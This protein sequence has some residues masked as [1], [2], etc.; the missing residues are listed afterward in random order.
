MDEASACVVG[1]WVDGWV[2]YVCVVL[3]LGGGICTMLCGEYNVGLLEGL[4]NYF[5]ECFI[6]I[7]EFFLGND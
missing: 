6:Y 1:S 3:V 2:G 4:L 5:R 7:F